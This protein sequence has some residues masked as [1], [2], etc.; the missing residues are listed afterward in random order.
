MRHCRELASGKKVVVPDSLV[1]TYRSSGHTAKQ[2]VSQHNAGFSV[3]LGPTIR[4][5]APVF[6]SLELVAADISCA[7]AQQAALA[8]RHMTHGT[9]G[10]C[11]ALGRWGCGLAAVSVE[12]CSLSERRARWFRVRWTKR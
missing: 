1:L 4:P 11:S 9:W 6:G 3:A 12:R 5:C 7:V 2:T 10:D 8:C